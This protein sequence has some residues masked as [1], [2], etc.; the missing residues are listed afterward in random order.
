MVVGWLGAPLLP[1]RGKEDPTQG[2][3]KKR[4][5]AIWYRKGGGFGG[6]GWRREWVLVLSYCGRRDKASGESSEKKAR[7]TYNK[8]RVYPHPV[9]ITV[10]L[11]ERRSR[12]Q[13]KK[14]LHLARRGTSAYPSADDKKSLFL[15]GA[16][17]VKETWGGGSFTL[18]G[19]CAAGERR[20]EQK[21]GF[22]KGRGEEPSTAT[23]KATVSEEVS[24]LSPKRKHQRGE[25]G[26]GPN[27]RNRRERALTKGY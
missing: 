25:S 13:M 19:G 6:V 15:R 18:S 17:K 14:R 11:R 8:G 20:I 22:Y 27:T 21:S 7:K 10:L 23:K 1:G 2:Q 5:P 4:G 9:L 16:K 26:G 12:E 24:P 3:K